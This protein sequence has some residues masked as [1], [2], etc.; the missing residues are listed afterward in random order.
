MVKSKTAAVGKIKKKDG[1]VREILKNWMAYLMALPGLLL[2]LVFCYLPMCGVIVA[3]K[4]YS[5]ARGIF[6]SDWVGV[7]Q[8]TQF[9]Q[10]PYFVRCLKNTLGISIYTLVVTFPMAIMLALLLNE[11]KSNLYKRCV[12]TITYIP[13]FI[14]TVVIAGIIID[15]TASDGVINDII[16]FFGFE[17]T[18]LLMRPE[19]FK[20]IYV[21]SALWQSLGW[22]SIVYL[23]ALTAI[24]ASLYEAAMLDGAGRFKQTIHV[25]IPGIIPTIVTMLILNIGGLMGVGYEKIILLYNPT[26]YETAETISTYVYQKGLVDMNFSYSTAIGLFNS[27]INLILLL[28][29][30]TI[31]KKFT[32]VGLW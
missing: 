26:T 6:G 7:E 31:S 15:F 12:Q 4:D 14:S 23:A 29:T 5:P 21:I 25:T 13:H 19:L 27:V 17:R 28:A 9:F 32:E 3:F 16:A 24:D 10:S 2:L 30:N 22:S 20:T 8:F 1:F 11:L 18:N